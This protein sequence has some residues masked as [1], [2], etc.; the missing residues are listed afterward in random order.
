[1]DNIEHDLT[2]EELKGKQ[3]VR[4]T[5]RLPQQVIDLLSVI[6]SQLGIKQ[7]SLFDQLIESRSVLKKIADEVQ[8]HPDGT[9]DRVQKTYV[10]SRSTLTTLDY[11]ARN[12]NI[13]RDTLV[14]ISIKR[15]LPIIE[16]ELEK[17]QKRKVL[18]QEMK[19][20]SRQG[21]FLLKKAKTL[22]GAEDQLYEM[23]K[24]QVKITERNVAT[25]KEIVRKGKLMEDW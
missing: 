11:V 15:L 3:S 21:K 18:L 17:H 24:H 1:M 9:K 6:A 14:E 22:L 7:K 20:Y 16:T 12:R 25:V 5:F 10:I 2:L 13:P 23:I 19:N 4:A 8:N